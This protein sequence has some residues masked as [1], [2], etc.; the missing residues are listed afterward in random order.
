MKHSV[1]LFLLFLFILHGGGPT[2]GLAAE[3]ESSLEFKLKTQC[4]K[5]YNAGIADCEKRH[6]DDKD[7]NSGMMESCLGE[8]KDNFKKC[9]DEA[10]AKAQSE[11]GKDKKGREKE[12]LLKRWTF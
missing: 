8:A 12:E 5:E 9:M 1:F 2:P 10:K 4:Q 6:I 11:E 3:D 7:R